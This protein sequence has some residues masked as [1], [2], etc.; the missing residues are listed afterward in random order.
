LV[1]GLLL[2]MLLLM[3]I[4]ELT[5][6][7]SPTRDAVMYTLTGP[8]SWLF[9][10]FLIGMGV[11]VPLIILFHPKAKKSICGV[12]VASVLIV[13]GVFVKRYYL[14]IPGAA[15]PLHYYPGKIEGVWGAVGSFAFAPAEIILSV[16]IVAFLGLIFVLGLKYLELLPAKEPVKVLAKGSGEEEAKESKDAT[17]PAPGPAAA[18][19]GE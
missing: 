12:V 9:W 6:I 13:I 16:G 8:F 2:G 14:V 17:D 19:E 3:I 15:Y 10:V 18:S 11:I 7:Y 5:H 4:G 1:K